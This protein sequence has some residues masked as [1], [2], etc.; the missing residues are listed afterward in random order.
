L[1]LFEQL[2]FM[3]APL[4]AHKED[5]QGRREV[6]SLG[7][8]GRDGHEILSKPKLTRFLYMAFVAQKQLHVTL[9]E[10]ENGDIVVTAH[11][12]WSPY[13]VFKAYEHL[14]GVGYD[15]EKGVHLTGW[16][17]RNVKRF[18][19]ADGTDTPNPNVEFSP[20]LF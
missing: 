6:A 20:A 10:D 14:R 12:E 11:Y 9:F 15:V 16:K 2:G 8:Y 7:Y 17:L 5:W 19:V 13:F 3:A 18:E 1:E 4:A